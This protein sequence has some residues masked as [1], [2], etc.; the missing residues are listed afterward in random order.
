MQGQPP[1]VLPD[2][3]AGDGHCRQ[4]VDD[5]GQ[6][7]QP[8]GWRDADVYLCG[9]GLLPVLALQFGPQHK[10]IVAW[11]QTAEHHVVVAAIVVPLVAQSLHHVRIF[12]FV[13]LRVVFYGVGDAQ[14]VLLVVQSQSAVVVGR[15][16][17]VYVVLFGRVKHLAQGDSQW[18][19]FLADASHLW[20]QVACAFWRSEHQHTV[21]S[22]C[23][24]PLHESVDAPSALLHVVV[25]SSC[26]RVKAEQAGIGGAPDA[27]LAVILYGSHLVVSQSFFLSIGLQRFPRPRSDVLHVGYADD[28]FAGGQP[29]CALSVGQCL[30]DIV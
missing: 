8:E 2:E 12:R 21:G 26:R 23:H 22:P 16:K 7:R 6:P 25:E 20:L 17:P 27:S 29:Y 18:R 1:L 24:R 30:V 15:D 5:P 4:C 3:P 9:G 10:G 14:C 19:H 28:A 13:R 11:T